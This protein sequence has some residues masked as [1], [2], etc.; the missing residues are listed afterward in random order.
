MRIE[1]KFYTVKISI[2]YEEDMCGNTNIFIAGIF[3]DKEEA[4]DFKNSLEQ[5]FAIDKNIFINKY[6]EEEYGPEEGYLRSHI[7]V[8]FNIDEIDIN[9]KTFACVAE[10][11]E[12]LPEYYG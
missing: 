11:A 4:E 2:Y 5:E 12:P 6:I 3:T 8:N 10:L 7:F 1:G 9:T